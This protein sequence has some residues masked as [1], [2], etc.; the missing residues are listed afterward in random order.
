M[1]EK[2]KKPKKPKIGIM[3][4]CDPEEINYLHNEMN[5]ALERALEKHKMEEER[6]FR[7][8]YKSGW[9]FALLMMKQGYSLKQIDAMFERVYTWKVKTPMTQRPTPVFSQYLKDPHPEKPN[10]LLND[11]ERSMIASYTRQR[12]LTIIK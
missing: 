1:T 6:R 5:K 12:K 9:Y 8:G 10:P 11:G 3:T 4:N 2:A 7:K